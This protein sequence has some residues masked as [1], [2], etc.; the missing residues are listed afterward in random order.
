VDIG[1][2][3]WQKENNNKSSALNSWIWARNAIVAEN[4]KIWTV[5]FNCGSNGNLNCEEE[6]KKVPLVL[7]HGLCASLGLWAVNIDNLAKDGRT[8]YAIDLLGNLTFIEIKISKLIF[9]NSI[10]FF[11]VKVLAEVRDQSFHRL[12]KK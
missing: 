6:K 7:L 11:L 1:L 12:Q 8:I 5:K 4:R 3:E 10:L 2:S 9:E